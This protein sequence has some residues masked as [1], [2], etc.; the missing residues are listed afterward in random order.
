MENTVKRVLLIILTI[1]IL[2]P[3]VFIGACFPLGLG[4]VLF[5][6]RLANQ[7]L[8]VLAFVLAIALAIFVIYKVIKSINKK[9]N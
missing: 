6:N 1:L 7:G 9:Y 4:A 3:L 2:G 5:S 8:I